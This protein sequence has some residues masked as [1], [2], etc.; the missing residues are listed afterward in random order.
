MLAGEKISSGGGL[1]FLRRVCDKPPVN[2]GHT[3]MA[4][5]WHQSIRLLNNPPNAQAANSPFGKRAMIRSFKLRGPRERA[6]GSI[7]RV[8]HNLLSYRGGRSIPSLRVPECSFHVS[9][10]KVSTNVGLTSD[11]I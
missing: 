3:D 7:E 11:I 9:F 10:K 4:P 2:A 6:F 8:L 5:R 1:D